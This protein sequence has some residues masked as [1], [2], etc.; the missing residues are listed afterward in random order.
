MALQRL[1]Y[2]STSLYGGVQAAPT[3]MQPAGTMD[4]TQPQPMVPP[5]AEAIEPE[6]M[7]APKTPD[8]NSPYANDVSWSSPQIEQPEAPTPMPTMPSAQAP[9]Y[10]YMEGVDTSK[11]YDTSHNSPKYLISR[12]LASGVPMSEAIKAVPGTIQLDATRFLL[13]GEIIDTRRDEE[14]ANA[15][16][17]LVIGDPNQQPAAPTSGTAFDQYGSSMGM[18]QLLASLSGGSSSSLAYHDPNEAV[19]DANGNPLDLPGPDYDAQGGYWSTDNT[20]APYYVSR[21]MLDGL[22]QM[23]VQ[24]LSAPS[25]SSSSAP[26]PPV[27]LAGGGSQT[28]PGGAQI[29]TSTDPNLSGI[30]DSGI[31]RLSQTGATPYGDEIAETL[32]QI[33][34]GGGV[35]PDFS[36]KLIGAR[37][38]AAQAMNAQLADADAALGARGIASTPGVN[39]G[40]TTGAIERISGDIS[41]DY[42]GALRDIYN[43]ALDESNESFMTSL[44]LATGLSGQQASQ[45]LQALGTGTQRQVGIAQIALTSLSQN[46]QWNQFLAQHGLD[47]A[48]LQNDIQMGRFDLLARLAQIYMQGAGQAAGGYY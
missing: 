3:P 19:L 28:L 15:L 22:G 37:E 40:P 38:D 7:F 17:W 13:N 20:G 33:I 48:R 25:G 47:T 29:P 46:M 31:A 21:E 1:P 43:T 44:S 32:R 41:E 11:M 5:T 39:Q 26:P 34:A 6:A 4:P 14:G 42:S 12:Q 45:M 23:P 35:N 24:T 18:A 10:Q 8:I 36:Q 27:S 16:Q 9:Q 30:I 2:T